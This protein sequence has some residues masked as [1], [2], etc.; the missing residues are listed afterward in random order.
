MH[1]VRAQQSLSHVLTVRVKRRVDLLAQVRQLDAGE[2]TPVARMLVG[3]VLVYALRG[4]DPDVAVGRGLVQAQRLGHRRH[5]LAGIEHQH[6]RDF[7]VAFIIAPLL[8]PLP[9]LHAL[10]CCLPFH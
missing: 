4:K 10:S 8:L 7:D 1:L 9:Q 3:Q 5:G 2:Q 6:H